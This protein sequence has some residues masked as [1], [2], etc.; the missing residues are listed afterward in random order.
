MTSMGEHRISTSS[1][2]VTDP[3]CTRGGLIFIYILSTSTSDVGR[4][5]LGNRLFGL[6]TLLERYHSRRT[7]FA[8]IVVKLWVEGSSG[9]ED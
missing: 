1:S 6:C 4:P 2:A 7:F 3:Y 9:Q 5:G 8:L